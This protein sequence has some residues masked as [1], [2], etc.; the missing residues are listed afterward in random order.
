[1]NMIR[2]LTASLVAATLLAPAIAVAQN[3]EL[4]GRGFVYSNAAQGAALGWVFSGPSFEVLDSAPFE[5]TQV[6]A[7]APFSADAVTEFTQ[8]LGDGNRIERS[9]K[10][11]LARD[12][13]GRTRREEQIALL[14]PLAGK[15]EPPTM[16]TLSDPAAGLHYTLDEKSKTARR[17]RMAMGFATTEKMTANVRGS[18]KATAFAFTV[19]NQAGRGVDSGGA[20]AAFFE[21]R[22][23][24]MNTVTT[25]LGTQRM[26]GVEVEGT[27]TTTTIPAGTI[28]NQLPIDVVSE[29]WFSKE[30]QMAVLITRKDPRSGETTYR[31][32]NI[33]RAEPPEDLFAVPRDYQV[34]DGARLQIQKIEMQKLQKLQDK[35]KKAESAK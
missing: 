32:T 20:T 6:V 30:L 18:E 2:H 34:D 22:V 3:T 21:T 31:L 7:G 17:E 4:G 26:E 27:R 16:I 25:S 1:M 24:E 8:T 13:R 33:V 35:I 29:R 10:A 23:P 12:G 9:F 14:G 15:G 28:G 19:G 11:S 5:S